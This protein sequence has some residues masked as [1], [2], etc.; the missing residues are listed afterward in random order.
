MKMEL[1][2]EWFLLDNFLMNYLM[3]R[4][5]SAFS[6]LPLRRAAGAGAALAGAAYAYASIALLPPLASPIPKLLL[7]CVVALPLVYHVKD[8]FRALMFL[9]L[10]A[11]LMGGL[12]LCI[13]LFFGGTMAGGV[14]VGTLP[15][16]LALA[17]AA[18]L[19]A[20]PRGVRTLARAYR[21]REKHVLLRI[22]VA[23]KTLEL[24]ALADSGNLLVEPLSGLPVV[25]VNAGL[26]D[27]PLED[28]RP[29]PYRTL[30]GTGYL[31]AVRP[32]RACAFDRRWR[33]LDVMVAESP[34]LIDGADAVIDSALLTA[35]RGKPHVKRAEG[36]DNPVVSAPDFDE[37][38]GYLLHSFGRDAAAAVCGAGGTGVDREVDA[39]G[40]GGQGCA[41]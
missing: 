40:T 5:A 17:G 11:F 18:V 20:L 25:V 10:S 13:C 27:K 6:G 22:E 26:M 37:T 16:R 3:L 30:D 2:I 39:G 15:V 34:L 36:L 33:R 31:L 21:L 35:E 29:V 32:R 8:F 12:M 19:A 4:L 9:Y 14:L 7:G 41:D 38:A 28:C 24:T 23:G 1:S